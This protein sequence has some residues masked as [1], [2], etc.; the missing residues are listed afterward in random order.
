MALNAVVSGFDSDLESDIAKVLEYRYGD[1]LVYLPKHQ[2]ESLFR[3]AISHGFID[4]E[5]YLTRKGRNLL[6][7]YQF[8]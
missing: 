6:A 4:G 7:K 2:P 1:G 5:G 3:M 8:C